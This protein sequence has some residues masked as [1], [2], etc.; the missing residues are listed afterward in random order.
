MNPFK[1]FKNH[2]FLA[3]S[4][5]PNLKEMSESNALPTL[6]RIRGAIMVIPIKYDIPFINPASF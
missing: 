1:L 6:L 4:Y 2:K 3:I 5:T